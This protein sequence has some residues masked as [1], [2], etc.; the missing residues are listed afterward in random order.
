MARKRLAISVND[1]RAMG[2]GAQHCS[3]SNLHSGSQKL[4]TG[5]LKVLLTMPPAGER[6]TETTK[7]RLVNYEATPVSIKSCDIYLLAN[8]NL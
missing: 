7:K 4:G 6:D 8:T 1:G 5:G 2:S 3:I